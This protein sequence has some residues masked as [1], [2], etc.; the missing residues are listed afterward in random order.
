MRSEI[1][2][3]MHACSNHT[4]APGKDRARV[5]YIYQYKAPQK[6][7]ITSL[8]NVLFQTFDR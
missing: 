3:C 4:I 7:T 8:T 1:L 6:D 5:E 2:E